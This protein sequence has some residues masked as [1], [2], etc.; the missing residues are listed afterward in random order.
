VPTRQPTGRVND[1]LNPGP[2]A[3]KKTYLSSTNPS[4]GPRSYQVSGQD[5]DSSYTAAF[6]FSSS[7][8]Q[9]PATVNFD[10]GNEWDDWDESDDFG[11]GDFVSS[12]H[13]TGTALPTACQAEVKASIQPTT[14]DNTLRGGVHFS[15]LIR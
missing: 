6:S 14:G 8:S 13:G 15:S 3:K 1:G 7:S 2:Y 12:G 9:A 5:V 4:V 10:L 11:N